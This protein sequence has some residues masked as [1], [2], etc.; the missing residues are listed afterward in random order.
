M[1]IED[2]VGIQNDNEKYGTRLLV[3][4]KETSTMMYEL[5]KARDGEVFSINNFGEKRLMIQDMS[6]DMKFVAVIGVPFEV[7]H[8]VVRD[9]LSRFGEVHDV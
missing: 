7:P 2:L 8:N 6:S 5:M 4:F 3:K 9:V 1:T